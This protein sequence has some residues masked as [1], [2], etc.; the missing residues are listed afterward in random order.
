[1][2]CLFTNNV[3]SR[4]NRTNYEAFI[5]VKNCNYSMRSVVGERETDEQKD[6]G[7]KWK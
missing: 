4:Y 2:T 6:N 1:M 5:Q 7:E 3:S